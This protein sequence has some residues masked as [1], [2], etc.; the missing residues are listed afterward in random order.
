M[1]SP[2]Q[3]ED[4]R[5]ILQDHGMKQYL[6]YGPRLAS[7]E[8]EMK[9]TATKADFLTTEKSMAETKYDMGERIASFQAHFDAKFFRALLVIITII[10]SFGIALLTAI[11]SDRPIE[12]VKQPAPVPEV[13]APQ[14]EIIK[15]P[16]PIPEV[17]APQKPE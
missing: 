7:I 3:R 1:S 17:H 9:H 11:F 6:N 4:L 5:V 13:H 10:V 2:S 16:A 14:I 15:Q 8:T 12:I